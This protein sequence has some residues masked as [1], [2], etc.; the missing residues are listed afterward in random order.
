M[1][2]NVR[3]LNCRYTKDKEF[4][5][6]PFFVWGSYSDSFVWPIMVE[7]GE[8]FIDESVVA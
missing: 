4:V 8:V 3:L 7:Y 2:R 5:S 1:S 6:K